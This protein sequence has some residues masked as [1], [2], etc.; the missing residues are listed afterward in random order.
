[1]S[2]NI[3]D[4]KDTVGLRRGLNNYTNM[5]LSLVPRRIKV[6]D[7]SKMTMNSSGN[8]SGSCLF[9]FHFPLA[10]PVDFPYFS[11]YS[12]ISL[13]NNVGNSLNPKPYSIR[14]LH[15][16]PRQEPLHQRQ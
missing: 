9:P 5:L 14:P 6:L 1:M 2:C 12:N 11:T 8:Y 10:F 4:A 3:A 16:A 13:R 7:A 15:D